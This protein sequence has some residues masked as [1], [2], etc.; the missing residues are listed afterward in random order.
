M[1]RDVAIR[2][3]RS[4]LW[5]WPVV[6]CVSAL[7]DVLRSQRA[8]RDRIAAA[9]DRY[10]SSSILD[11]ATPRGTLYATCAARSKRL[12]DLP[13]NADVARSSR[14]RKESI[15]LGKRAAWFFWS[16]NPAMSDHDAIG[17]PPV[18]P[19]VSSVLRAST[20]TISSSHAT[21][22]GGGVCSLLRF[23]CDR[24]EPSTHRE[25]NR[26]GMTQYS[27]PTVVILPPLRARLS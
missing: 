1:I 11:K 24:A 4:S 26:D 10:H 9:E 14:Q 8:A 23:L 25:S 7:Q 5:S 16:T 2:E 6:P 27:L 13:G 21:D 3:W 12:P 18:D 19:T 20:T 15:L 22:R 17:E